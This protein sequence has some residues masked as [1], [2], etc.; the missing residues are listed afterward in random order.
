MS[1]IRRSTMQQKT[2]ASRRYLFLLIPLAIICLLLA[3]ACYGVARIVFPPEV[4]AP[5]AFPDADIIFVPSGKEVGF[6]NA[7]GANPEYVHLVVKVYGDTSLIWPW[8]PVITG[9]NKTL[10]VKVADHIKYVYAPHYLALSQT[11]QLPVLCTQWGFQQMAYLSP[12][13]QDIFIQTDKGTDRYKLS[14]CGTEVAP[15]ETYENVFG[16]PSPDLQYAAYINTK[17]DRSQ[18][19]VTIRNIKS[20]KEQVI[21][22]GNYPVWSRDGRWLAYTGPDGIYIFNVEEDMQPRRVIFYPNLFDKIYP[23]Y[24]GVSS[25]GIPP[26]VSWSPDGKWMVYHKWLGIRHD[27]TADPSTYAIYKLNI[28]TGEE[29]KIIDG[30]MYPY[31]RWPVEEP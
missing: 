12:D 6:V 9:D 28:E 1:L 25:W 14:S 29:I 17:Y 4:R 31:W 19:A 7:D 10:V 30:G 22:E 8:R 3:T 11:G 18:P 16:L 20:G 5:E 26:E 15:L 2:I 23:T 27:D 13:Q 24:F 21:G